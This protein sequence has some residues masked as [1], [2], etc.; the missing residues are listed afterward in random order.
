[1]FGASTIDNPNLWV[2]FLAGLPFVMVWGF[3]AEFIDQATDAEANWDK[4]L[5]NLGSWVWKNK[6]DTPNFFMGIVALTYVVQLATIAT[7]VLE[8][9]SIISVAAMPFFLYGSAMLGKDFGK[10]PVLTLLFGIFVH[11]IGLVVGQGI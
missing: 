7:G 11:M 4:G 3:A 9:K 1:M 5:R 8:P 2:A 10:I 6:I